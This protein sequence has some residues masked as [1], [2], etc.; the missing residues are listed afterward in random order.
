M[1]NSHQD[2]NASEP[3][4]NKKD[5]KSDRIR[6]ARRDVITKAMLEKGNIADKHPVIINRSTV[7]W[8]D[9]PSKEKEVFEKYYKRIH[10]KLPEEDGFEFKE[11]K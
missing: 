7:V 11:D 3:S 8:I 1:A 10:G 4:A 9:D 6:K 5:A 2:I